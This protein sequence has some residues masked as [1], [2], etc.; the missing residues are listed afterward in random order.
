MD[1]KRKL[2]LDDTGSALPLPGTSMGPSSR[3]TELLGADQVNPY[4]GRAYSQR[5]H[6]ILAGRK[7]AWCMASSGH[8]VK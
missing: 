4:T 8:L 6:Q 5:Y 3:A 7:G 2:E 1:R